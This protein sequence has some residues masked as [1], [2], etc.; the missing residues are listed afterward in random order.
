M[1]HVPHM[2][3][4]VTEVDDETLEDIKIAERFLVWSAISSRS[5]RMEA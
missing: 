3:F 2:V 4:S 5:K 1:V